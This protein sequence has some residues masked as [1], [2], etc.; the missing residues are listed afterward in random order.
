MLNYNGFNAN[1]ITMQGAK[2]TQLNHKPVKMNND[3]TVALAAKDDDFIGYCV[4]D[5]DAIKGVQM[6][7]YMEAEYTG[8]ISKLGWMHLVS[9]GDGKV[10]VSTATGPMYRVIK[11]DT[12]N[13]VVGFIL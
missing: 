4:S 13:K 7:G 11:L 8:T 10:A 3:G 2:D 9:N 6:Q 1:I 12:T 5:K